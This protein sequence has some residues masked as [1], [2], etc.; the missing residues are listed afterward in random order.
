MTNATLKEYLTRIYEAR[1]FLIHLVR[2]D[3][4]YKFRRSKLGMLWTI[5]QPLLLTLIMSAV[6]SY[7][8]RQ[9]MRT[10]APYILSGTLVWEIIQNS[11]IGNS[12]SFVAAEAYIRQY[13]HPIALY[14]L[15]TAL[16]SMSTFFIASSALFVWVLILF[17]ENILL[18]LISIPTTAL[19]YFMLSW[20]ISVISSHIFV[21]YRDYPY[22]M[23]LVMQ[24]LW[25]L[26]PVF[27]REEMFESNELLH[28][29]FLINPITQVLKLIRT[30]LFQGELAGAGTYG[31][32]LLLMCGFVLCAWKLNQA[33]EKTVIYYL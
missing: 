17:P 27:F 5:L 25:Y 4:K 16:V 10:Y 24:F 15:R 22:V 31:Y 1:Y 9:E 7:V 11:F 19:I 12:S 23:T 13:A 28:T 21:R 18:A 20:S 6:F 14:P 26:S 32:V 29:V 8:F 33:A 3:M 30:P 2:W